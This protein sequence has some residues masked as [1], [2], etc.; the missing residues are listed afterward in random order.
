MIISQMLNTR[1]TRSASQ[2]RKWQPIGIRNKCMWSYTATPP[3]TTRN[4]QN[5]MSGSPHSL[6]PL[7]SASVH[8]TGV[9][10]VSWVRCSR[11]VYPSGAP[12]PRTS[13]NWPMSLAYLIKWLNGRPISDLRPPTECHLPYGITVLYLPPDTAEPWTVNAPRHNPSR[14]SSRFTSTRGMETAN[15]IPE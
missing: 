8:K 9:F 13:D 10:H 11:Y 5:C 7:I 4:Q 14:A 3:L 1:L 12:W 2:S 15:N 6:V